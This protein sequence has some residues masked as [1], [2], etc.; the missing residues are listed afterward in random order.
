MTLPQQPTVKAE[1]LIRAAVAQVFQAFVDPEVTTRFW[2]HRS[3]G[4]LEAGKT[5]QW[6]WNICPDPAEVR[7][8]ALEEN[9]RILIDWGGPEEFTTVEWL[10]TARADDSTWASVTNSGF[11]GDGGSVVSQALDSMGGFTLVLAAAKV[12]LEH[13]INLNIVADR[14][15]DAE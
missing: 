9:R 12:F 11:Q 10:F 6:Y 14:F 8:K 4:K 2:F 3:T 1:F 15:P 13:G 7:V 5:V